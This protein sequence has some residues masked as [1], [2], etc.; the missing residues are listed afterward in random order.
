MQS[1]K[2]MFSSCRHL[3]LAPVTSTN[4]A[5]A[6]EPGGE[7][8]TTEGRR[9]EEH[10]CKVA[11]WKGWTVYIPVKTEILYLTKKVYEPSLDMYKLF[12]KRKTFSQ[13]K[14]RAVSERQS[15]V[16]QWLEHS[17]RFACGG[18][19]VRFPVPPV[20]N[21]FFNGYKPSPSLVLG[22]SEMGCLVKGSLAIPH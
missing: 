7:F 12:N 21:W 14:W 22:F 20:T 8:S 15:T 19:A 17:I 2:F 3:S 9:G 6:L 10:M 4:C 13:Y 11:V 16:A 1:G 18:C 5:H